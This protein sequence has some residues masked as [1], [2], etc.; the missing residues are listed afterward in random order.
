MS[1]DDTHTKGVCFMLKKLKMR[2]WLMC[3]KLFV[4]GDGFSNG[5]SGSSTLSVDIDQCNDSEWD[6]TNDCQEIWDFDPNKRLGSIQSIF[7]KFSEF[8]VFK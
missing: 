5:K 8:T 4:L 7:F 1:Y 2:Y 3:L 6:G